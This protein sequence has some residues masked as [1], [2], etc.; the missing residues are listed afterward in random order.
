MCLYFSP[1]DIAFFDDAIHSALPADAVAISADLHRQMMD[2]QA[3]GRIIVADGDG[4]PMTIAPPPPTDAQLLAA[5]RQRRN[6]LLADCDH[7]QMP[8]VSLTDE[9]RAE[10]RQYRQALRDLPETV[11][12]LTAIDWPIAPTI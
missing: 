3:T 7:T 9:Q 5:L 10:W 2:E 12:D 11:A 6:G 8:D 4:M 1:G